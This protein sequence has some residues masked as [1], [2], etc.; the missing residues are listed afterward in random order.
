M[1]FDYN[2]HIQ[3]LLTDIGYRYE[4]IP[5]Y[6]ATYWSPFHTWMLYTLGPTSPCN[7]KQLTELEQVAGGIVEASI[8]L[9][10][11]RHKACLAKLTAL[12]VVIDDSI[13]DEAKLYLGEAQQNGLLG[14]Y[15]ES[16][17]ELSEIYGNDAVLRGCSRCPLD[18]LRR[19]VPNGKGYFDL[20]GRTTDLE[21][22]ALKF[23]RTSPDYLRLKSGIAEAYAAGIFKATK[24]QIFPLRRYIK[25]LPDVTFFINAMN[26]VLSFHKEELA[27]ET[28][29]LIHLRTRSLS[30]SGERG[31]GHAGKWTHYDTFQ[32]LCEEL[33]QATRRIDG[34][35][36]LEECERRMRGDP[37]MDG[38]DEL[39]IQLAKQWR[40]F[41]DG[42]VSW[43]VECRRY[44]LDFIKAVIKMWELESP[45]SKAGIKSDYPKVHRD[46]HFVKVFVFNI[47]QTP[48]SPGGVRKLSKFDTLDGFLSFRG[49]ETE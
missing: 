4:A 9:C 45:A 14:L 24:D 29:N 42:Y 8:S 13:E 30:A 5:T 15:H 3:R 31:S 36:R 7:V 39:D 37:G 38:I 19:R 46:N 35:L 2:T 10:K 12:V 32:L 26:D 23:L 48:N 33:R 43:H 20:R 47:R 27:G 21:A 18:N 34:L 16:M 28:Y 11:R 25:V 44:K 17:K 1:V 6:D 49:L 22:F 41:R 40:K